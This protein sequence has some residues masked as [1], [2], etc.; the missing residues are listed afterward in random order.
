M[1][2]YPC[3]PLSAVFTVCLVLIGGLSLLVKWGSVI[4]LSIAISVLVSLIVIVPIIA[5]GSFG[6]ILPFIS[7]KMGS[8][9]YDEKISY[10][11]WSERG[12]HIWRYFWTAYL[13]VALGA[14][15]CWFFPPIGKSLLET[16]QQ[17]VPQ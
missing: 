4:S 16:V 12:G 9:L 7:H 5:A 2:I 3:V 10:S 1:L 14:G 8:E 13:S 6:I 11:S 17:F 15:M